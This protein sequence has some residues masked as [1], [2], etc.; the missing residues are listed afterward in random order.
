MFDVRCVWFL[1]LWSSEAIVTLSSPPHCGRGWWEDVDWVSHCLSSHNNNNRDVTP[2]ITRSWEMRESQL[3]PKHFELLIKTHHT[4]RVFLT[5]P[6]SLLPL[7]S[8]LESPNRQ[9][10]TAGP[11]LHNYQP[12]RIKTI[13]QRSVKRRLLRSGTGKSF[14]KTSKNVRP[15]PRSDLST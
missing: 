12:G 10:I 1:A 14:L 9:L 11:S 15:Q 6:P 4:L 2:I 13:L 7:S 8:V 5:W 3:R